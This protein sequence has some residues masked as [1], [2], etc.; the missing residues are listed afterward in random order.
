[1]TPTQ[2]LANLDAA[3]ERFAEII[4]SKRP[5]LPFSPLTLAE[6][7][8]RVLDANLT[9]AHAFRGATRSGRELDEYDM[10]HM[11]E[12]AAAA[13]SYSAA[14]VQRATQFAHGVSR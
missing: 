6:L 2:R 13:E 9:I 10:E 14:A 8:E 12:A 11:T 4:D 1:M 7:N 3:R 5:T